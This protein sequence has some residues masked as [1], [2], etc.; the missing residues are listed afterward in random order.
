MSLTKISQPHGG[1]TNAADRP[2]CRLPIDID[3]VV[4][5][6]VLKSFPL[7]RKKNV[8]DSD[9]LLELGLVDSQGILELVSFIE[10]QFATTV[11]DDELMP[12][13]FQS[14]GCIAAFIRSKT[15]AP[16]C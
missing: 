1:A 14:I 11:E 9:P 5:E 15:A 8:Q 12:Q 2:D 13:N 7:A 4:R 6:F 10:R 3:R 16:N